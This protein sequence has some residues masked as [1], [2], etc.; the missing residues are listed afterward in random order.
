MI[1]N[2]DFNLVSS[3]LN[4]HLKRSELLSLQLEPK[5]DF[6]VSVNRSLPFEFI[7]SALTKNLELMDLKAN[8][9]FSEYDASL[10]SLAETTDD[11]NLLIFWIDWRLLQAK[12]TPENAVAWLSH[13]ISEARR[14]KNFPVIFNNWF[15]VPAMANHATGTFGKNKSWIRELNHLLFD[16]CKKTLDSE[17]LDFSEIEIISKS[18]VYDERNDKIANTP[19]SNDASLIIA[20]KIAFHFIPYF[21]HPRL[22]CIVCDLDN[23]LYSGVLGEDGIDGIKLTE[24]HKKLQLALCNLKESGILLAISS[25]NDQKDVDLMFE[26]RADFPLKASDFISIKANWEPKDEN[27]KKIANE[28][29]ISVDALLFI[30]DNPAELTKT[31][32]MLPTLNVLKASPEDAMLTL[33]A[34]CFYPGIYAKTVDETSKQRELDLKASK[35]RQE[36]LETAGDGENYLKALE[37]EV[38]ISFNNSNYA[39]RIKD[40]SNKTNQ[41]NTNFKRMDQ[42]QVDSILKAPFI[43]STVELKDKFADSGI[44]GV[45]SSNVDS[46]LATFDEILYSCRALG[47]GIESVAFK[48]HLIETQKFGAK[49]FKI[50]YQKAPRN[51]PAIK[52]LNFLE[53]ESDKIYSINEKVSFIDSKIDASYINFKK[54]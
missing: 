1:K 35:L 7:S 54:G 4:G 52:W 34:L 41:F 27:I 46:E 49:K 18:A 44:I 43:T 39:T 13:R 29:N 19:L 3:L 2:T 23:T 51:E 48:H 42:T 21:K 38:T 25:K 16:L 15:E 26:K 32:G 6:K 30:D 17:I 8:F 47:R 50:I 53:I 9:S 33:K 5:Y 36:L 24:S 40:L 45:F 10:S 22:K 11:T 28:I 12:N 31:K 37:M 20:Q 14:L